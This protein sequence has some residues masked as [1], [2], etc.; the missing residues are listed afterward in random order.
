MLQQE[1]DYSTVD[2][3]GKTAKNF[4]K[5]LAQSECRPVLGMSGRGLQPVE[6]CTH[7]SENDL[8]AKDEEKPKDWEENKNNSLQNYAL[9]SE[10]GFWAIIIICYVEKEEK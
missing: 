2:E 1:T 9:F 10:M 5:T 8:L 3:T 6:R 7:I 4:Q